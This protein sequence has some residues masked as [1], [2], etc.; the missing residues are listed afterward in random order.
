[1]YR[2]LLL[3]RTAI[4]F[5][6]LRQSEQTFFTALHEEEVVVHVQKRDGEHD[7]RRHRLIEAPVL[8]R[9]VRDQGQD[10]P[11][12]HRESR[13]DKSSLHVRRGFEFSHPSF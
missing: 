13:N 4:P 9:D 5:L 6:L 8:D 12:N 7:G 3:A 2:D 10:D 1:M 11:L